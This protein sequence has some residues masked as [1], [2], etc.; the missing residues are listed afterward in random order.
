MILEQR[1]QALD[2]F[3]GVAQGGA[4]FQLQIDHQLQPPRCREELLRDKAKQHHRA[5]KQQHGQGDDGFAPTHA[6]LHQPPDPLV[7]RCPVRVGLAVTD[8]VLGCMDFRQVRQELLSQVGHEHHGSHP[9]GQQCEGHHLE[10]RAGVFAGARLRRGDGQESR[11]RDQRTGEH[12][13]RRARPGV[14]GRL[15]PVEAL[16]HLD[17]HHL[18]RND[19]VIHQQPERQHQRAQGNLVQADSQVIHRREGHCQHQWNRQGDHHPGT[20]PQGKEAHQQDDR[21]RFHQHLDEL[22]NASLHRRRLVRHL[23]QLH[24]GRQVVL[25]PGKLGFQRLAQDQDVAPLLHRHGQ[26]N[27]IFAH[28]THAWRRRFV[29][30]ATHVR[31]IVDT[32]CAI[33]DPDR[34][35]AD[36]FHRLEIPR[37]P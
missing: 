26:A 23:A 15:D 11:R 32:E 34:E 7:E 33:G 29:E 24:A 17:C 2:L 13:E 1:L 35:I 19:R 14:A 6:P 21:Q 8:P 25:D 31:H 18:H 4:F 12:R 28:E 30:T 16:L 9:G 5:D 10:N 22:T 36:L 20:Q 27:G 3:G 37:H